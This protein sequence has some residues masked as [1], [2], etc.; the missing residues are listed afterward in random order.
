MGC[1]QNFESLLQAKCLQSAYLLNWLGPGAMLNVV[2]V[3]QREGERGMTSSLSASLACSACLTSP[4][5]PL[6]FYPLVPS[7]LFKPSFCLSHQLAVSL[8]P[9][10]YLSF[11]P[12]D[13]CLLSLTRSV[14]LTFSCFLSLPPFVSS[15]FCPLLHTQISKRTPPNHFFF[16]SLFHYS[17]QVLSASHLIFPDSLSII[18]KH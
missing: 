1:S 13:V 8:I 7:S 16:S 10:L 18:L 14:V 9:H 2:V 3:S 12:S 4:P 6:D 11:S 17:E 5:C 15:S